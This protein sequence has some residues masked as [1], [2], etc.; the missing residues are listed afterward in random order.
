[1]PVVVKQILGALFFLVFCGVAGLCDW[2]LMRHIGIWWM[3]LLSSVFG[4]LNGFMIGVFLV[5]RSRRR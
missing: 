1:M 2:L 4:G 3:L 5:R